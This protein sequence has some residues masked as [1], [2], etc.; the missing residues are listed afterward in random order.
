MK[1]GSIYEDQQ[2]QQS[3]ASSNN[4]KNNQPDDE[5]IPEWM[6]DNPSDLTKDEQTEKMVLDSSHLEAWKVRMKQMDNNNNNN[7]HCD[8]DDNNNSTHLPTDNNEVDLL[9]ALESL[10]LSTTSN[11]NPVADQET[12]S[13][14]TISV[15]DLFQQHQHLPSPPSLSPHAQQQ[16]Q[17]Q[18][19]N[20]SS[21]SAM[22]TPSYLLSPRDDQIGGFGQILSKQS[23]ISKAI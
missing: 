13:A 3:G 15:H 5:A 9:L 19:T 10:Q 7:R 20:S 4:M 1:I 16:Q 6:D 18:Q 11:S 14:K 17:Q 22:D 2:Q 8:D 21:S 12:Y 23:I